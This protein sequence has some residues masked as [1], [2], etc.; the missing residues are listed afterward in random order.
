VIVYVLCGWY[1]V[2]S[3]GPLKQVKMVATRGSRKANAVAADGNEGSNEPGVQHDP[4]PDDANATE[5]NA[6]VADGNKDGREPYSNPKSKTSLPTPGGTRGNLNKTKMNATA[7]DGS[8]EAH[9]PCSDPKS[10]T[11]S[12]TP[13]DERQNSSKTMMIAAAVDRNKESRERCSSPKSKI[14]SSTQDDGDLWANERANA[15]STDAA[16]AENGSSVASQQPPD[17]S[18]EAN[19]G[20]DVNAGEGSHT[21]PESKK[22][23]TDIVMARVEENVDDQ[24]Q[25][26]A[27]TKRSKASQPSDGSTEAT[28]ANENDESHEPPA[29]K[30]SKTNP[31]HSSTEMSEVS[32]QPTLLMKANISDDANVNKKSRETPATRQRCCRLFKSSSESS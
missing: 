2:N 10:K 4:A 26:H 24:S 1:V 9:E 12:P 22:S 14:S 18:V 8:E 21:L 32:Q 23:K 29:T 7:A 27:C 16:R 13:K 25:K 5:A 3:V 6:T 19:V 31:P 11:S 30:K 17:E 28:A 15:V 20:A